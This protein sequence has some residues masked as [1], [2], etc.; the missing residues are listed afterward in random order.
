MSD[1]WKPVYEKIRTQFL[2]DVKKEVAEIDWA[3]NIFKDI[4][5]VVKAG[6]D[7]LAVFNG[8][9]DELEGLAPAD[10]R[11][12]FAQ[13]FDDVIKLPAYLEPWDDNVGAWIYDLFNQE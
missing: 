5:Q 10:R 6:I 11:S 7:I 13:G 3:G 2:A 1:A 4:A 12:M 9:V 8:Y